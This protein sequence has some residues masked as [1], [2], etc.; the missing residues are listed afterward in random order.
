[1]RK[2][3]FDIETKNFFQETG[4]NDPASLDLSIVCIY[5]YE[6]NKYLSFLEEELSEL[7][8]ILEKTDLL[9]GFNSNHF[10]VPIL[11]KYY[12]GNLK[13]IKSLD[14]M[15]EVKKSLGRRISLNE[16]AGATLGKKKIADGHEAVRW[17]KEGNIESLRRYCIED[18][19]ITKEVYDF[20][21]TNNKL[22][23]KDLGVIKTIPLETSSWEE[24]DKSAM[25][26]SLPI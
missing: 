8:K 7:W 10:D 6:E 25:T 12:P 26:F 19:R 9:I 4:S 1:M 18:V 13:K 2:V 14:I 15:E 22:N 20:A 11:N 5:D 23:Y 3:V 17:W 21:K 16:I 24:F